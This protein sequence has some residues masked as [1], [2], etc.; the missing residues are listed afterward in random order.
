MPLLDLVLGDSLALREA[1]RSLREQEDRV[2]RPVEGEDCDL[3]V[4]VRA[5]MPRFEALNARE[6]LGQARQTRKADAHLLVSAIG[7]AVIL[8]KLFGGFD[9][10]LKSLS[11]L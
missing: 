4:H 5:D 10:L 1:E 11:V 6:R 8:T 7:F 2:F 9:M 3:A